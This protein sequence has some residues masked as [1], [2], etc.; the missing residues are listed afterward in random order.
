MSTEFS[1]QGYWSGLPFPT[2]RHSP[3]VSYSPHKNPVRWVQL[4]LFY[5]WGNRGS[6]RSIPYLLEDTHL[7]DLKCNVAP[8]CHFQRCTIKNNSQWLKPPLKSRQKPGRT[9]LLSALTSHVLQADS[10]TDLT[11][12]LHDIT[13]KGWRQHSDLWLCDPAIFWPP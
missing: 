1:W 10:L 6:E 11:Y 2:P 8:W 3:K 9:A 7:C 12:L 4:F 5:R 13:R